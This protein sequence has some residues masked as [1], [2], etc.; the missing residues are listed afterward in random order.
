MNRY[1]RKLLF[2]SLI[3]ASFQF[4]SLMH[5]QSG[6]TTPPV[7]PP[8]PATTST[9]SGGTTSSG[10]VVLENP[11]GADAN[12]PRVLLGRI[13]QAIIGLSGAVA[14][15]MFIYSGLLFLTAGGNTSMI[16]KAKL[17]MLYTILGIIVIAGAFVATNTIFTA[18]LTGS[19]VVQQGSPGS[20]PGS[21]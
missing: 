12:D 15:V 13:I 18:V 11:L 7:G 2:F 20:A 16:Q 6:G 9:S 10:S 14:L 21:P 4:S 19:P 3:F 17:L 8:A 1:I 5:A